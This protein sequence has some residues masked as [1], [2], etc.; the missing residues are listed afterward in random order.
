L[1]IVSG[2]FK[3]L[4]YLLLTVESGKEEKVANELLNFKKV[5]DT[6]ILFGEYNMIA[7]VEAD[8]EADL[9]NFITNDLRHI[10]N[11]QSSS[12]LIVRN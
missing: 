7:E 8:N 4:A 5:K 3:I 9:K 12:T 6:H 10:K 1:L 11:I 2:V